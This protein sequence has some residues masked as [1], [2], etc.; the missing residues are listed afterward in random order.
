MSDLNEAGTDQQPEVVDLDQ[1]RGPDL[2]SDLGRGLDPERNRAIAEQAERE[3]AVRSMP[4]MPMPDRTSGAT[5]LATLVERGADLPTLEKFM[6]LR[7]REEARQAKL[8]FDR[9]FALM[10]GD[11][12]P[13]PRIKT[14]RDNDK[15]RDLYDYAP[16]E[17]MVQTNGRAIADHGFS[18]SFREEYLDARKV[19]RYYI[20]ITGWGH[21]RT[22]YVDLPE[23][24][25][26]AP[27]MNGAQKAASLQSYGHRYAMTAGFGM[28]ME[29]QDD[30]ARSL[31]FE[32]GVRLSNEISL[33]REAKNQEELKM[34]YM[35]AVKDKSDEDRK[36]IV[37]V[38]NQRLKEISGGRL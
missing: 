35:T 8:D 6:D 11:F 32:V 16:I 31:T 23:G 5:M 7:D 10:Q 29:D 22:T 34:A 2:F 37:T 1:A 13:V 21:T 38:K 18:Y 24:S 15:G 33:I 36:V 9:N 20:D 27:L 19:M 12:K 30:D 17:A 14:A 25:A 4:I 28:V 3:V 26:S